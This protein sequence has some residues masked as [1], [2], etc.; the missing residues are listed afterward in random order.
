MDI[1]IKVGEYQV[2]NSG[3]IV[4]LEGAPIVFHIGSLIISFE[5]INSQDD[6]E[7]MTI[8]KRVVS[9]LE[10]VIEFVN[11][12]SQLGSG[13][14]IPYVVGTF[15]NKELSFLVR[16]SQLNKGG[17]LVNYTWLTRDYPA[18]NEINNPV[19]TDTDPN[20][21]ENHG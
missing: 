15:Q 10:A 16:F 5:F 13:L 4:A 12:N 3:S 21:E 8:Q 19:E 1:G 6:T 7:Q 9:S 14:V 2:L 20:N 17:K 18:Q 11:F